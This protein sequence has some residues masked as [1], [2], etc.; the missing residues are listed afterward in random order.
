MIASIFV[1]VI[2]PIFAN[3]ILTVKFFTS[4][5]VRTRLGRLATL[6]FCGVDQSLPPSRS[7][8]ATKGCMEKIYTY[9]FCKKSCVIV[10]CQCTNCQFLS[11]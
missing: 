1:P 9:F 11:R 6:S 7:V 8:G 5:S 3:R 2:T 10:P 4:N